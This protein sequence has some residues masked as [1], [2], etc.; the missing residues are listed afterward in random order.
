MNIIEAA[1]QLKPGEVLESSGTSEGR[2]PE[3]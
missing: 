3:D 2:K 1:K